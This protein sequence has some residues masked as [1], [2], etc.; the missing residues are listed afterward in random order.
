MTLTGGPGFKPNK[1]IDQAWTE[2]DSYYHHNYAHDTGTEGFYIGANYADGSPVFRGL[3]I[4]YN[5][6]E[7][8]NWS[9]MDVKGGRERIKVHHNIIIATSQTLTDGG[10][11]IVDTLEGDFYNNWI[12][13]VHQKFAFK[14]RSNGVPRYPTLNKGSKKRRQSL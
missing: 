4:S 14:I 6:I 12:E 13:D 10:I 3:E 8:T 1:P 5:R 9:G 11:G 2:F 7:H